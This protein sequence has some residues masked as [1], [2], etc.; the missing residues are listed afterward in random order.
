[1]SIDTYLAFEARTGRPTVDKNIGTDDRL[2][3]KFRPINFSLEDL[4]ILIGIKK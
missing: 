4:N 3:M 2:N 1:M